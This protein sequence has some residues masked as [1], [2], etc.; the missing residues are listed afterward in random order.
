MYRK[1]RFNKVI[2]FPLGVPQWMGENPFLGFLVLLSFALLI[3]SIVFYRYVF[4]ERDAGTSSE[5]VQIRFDQQTL[6]RVIQ[7][8][9]EHEEK[10]NQAGKGLERN[11][12]APSQENQELTE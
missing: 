6:Q 10:F 12:F 7:T 9:Q 5:I 2:H 3:S 8:W 1:F 4:L 11:I